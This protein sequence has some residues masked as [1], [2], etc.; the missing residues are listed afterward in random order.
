M[1][2]RVATQADVVDMT[3]IINAD[4]LPCM[5]AITSTSVAATINGSSPSLLNDKQGPYFSGLE[6]LVAEDSGK[7][8]GTGCIGWGSGIGFGPQK[9]HRHILWLHAR[10]NRAVLDNLA[11]CL[12]EGA[13]IDTPTH[14][15]SWDGAFGPSSFGAIPYWHRPETSRVFTALGF[16]M[17]PTICLLQVIGSPSSDIVSYQICPALPEAEPG[18]ED[19]A[20]AVKIMANS[21]KPERIRIGAGR[22]AYE[23]LDATH[24]FLYA[25]RLTRWVVGPDEDKVW[26]PGSLPNGEERESPESLAVRCQLIRAARTELEHLGATEIAMFLFPRVAGLAERA[27]LRTE[28]FFV[29]DHFTAWDRP[30]GSD[31][32]ITVELLLP[33]GGNEPLD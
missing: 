6:M 19:E 25:P 24:G 5:P 18:N 30:E 13:P 2:V 23:L 28:G 22:M 32:T 16:A 33:G 31:E 4:R 9:D 1:D 3:E 21:E 29:V 26:I 12:L 10:E 11:Q 14:V 8:V 7:I 27:Q 17:T 20:A 15:G